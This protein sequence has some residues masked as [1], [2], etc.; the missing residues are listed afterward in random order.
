MNIEEQ[1]AQRGAVAIDEALFNGSSSQKDKHF[2][3][4]NDR[5]AGRQT[6]YTE[7]LIAFIPIIYRN[8]NNR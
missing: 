2:T 1:A 3:E 4:Q 7:L 6:L 5:E 8:Q